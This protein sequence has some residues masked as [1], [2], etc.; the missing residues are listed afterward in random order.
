MASLLATLLLWTEFKDHNGHVILVVPSP[1]QAS[2]CARGLLLLWELADIERASH[3]ME[4]LKSPLLEYVTPLNQQASD[5]IRARSRAQL[6]NL[7]R[8]LTR[9]LQATDVRALLSPR[10]HA[11]SGPRPIT[12]DVSRGHEPSHVRSDHRVTIDEH[13][14]R[15]RSERALAE[16]LQYVRGWTKDVGW[17]CW[18]PLSP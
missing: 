18:R 9:R 10:R 8:S 6:G 5:N 7:Y 11:S 17:I 14:L 4:N 3:Q 15:E 13:E 12:G 16:K 2:N 1:E